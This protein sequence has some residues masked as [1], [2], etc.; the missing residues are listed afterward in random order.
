MFEQFARGSN[1]LSLLK[2]EQRHKK[3]IEYKAL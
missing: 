3:N 2:S 1:D